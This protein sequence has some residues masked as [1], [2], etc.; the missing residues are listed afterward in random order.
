MAPIIPVQQNF[1]VQVH[2]VE[3]QRVEGQPL[4]ARIYQPV[5]TEAFAAVLDVLRL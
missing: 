3:Y 2:D 5:G 4:L 1:E